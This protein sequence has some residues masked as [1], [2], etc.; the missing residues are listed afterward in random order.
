[1]VRATE[2]SGR[3][4]FFAITDK[5]VNILADNLIKTR[6]FGIFLI[7]KGTARCE[8][9]FRPHTLQEGGLLILGDKCYFQCREA[10]ADFSLSLLVMTPEIWM[11]TAA[12]FGLSFFSFLRRHPYTEGKLISEEYRQELHSVIRTAERI[13]L[14]KRHSFRLQIFR[15]ITQNIL[16]DFYERMKSRLTGRNAANTTRQEKLFEDFIHLVS[17]NCTECRDVASYADKLC[18]TTR[19]LSSIVR[20]MTGS[21]PKD[22]INVHCVQEIKMLLSTTDRNIQE[23]AYMLHFPDQS[24]FARYFRRYSGMSPEEYRPSLRKK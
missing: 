7:E 16:F 22:I 11:E 20:N 6:H 24:Y 12:P 4:E 23:I 18:I 14:D 17:R 1:M 21:H 9:D 2:L 5:A 13:C 8:I 10:S 15:N 3:E 19:Y